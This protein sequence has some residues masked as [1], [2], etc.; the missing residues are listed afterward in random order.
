MSGKNRTYGNSTLIKLPAEKCSY[1]RKKRLICLKQKNLSKRWVLGTSIRCPDHLSRQFLTTACTFPYSSK[2]SST[3]HI[4]AFYTYR[5]VRECE[6]VRECECGWVWV[7]VFV[8]VCEWVSVCVFVY[9]SECVCGGE[10]C[11]WSVNM[12]GWGTFRAA[13]KGRGG[14]QE[15]SC[16]DDRGF[17]LR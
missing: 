7:C 8:C 15:L 9:V 2:N 5:C 11:W 6:S 1:R 4:H 10:P 16:W 3:E 17:S 14:G 12:L 13:W